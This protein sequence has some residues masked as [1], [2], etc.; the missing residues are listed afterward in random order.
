M[1]RETIYIIT[2]DTFFGNCCLE[3]HIYSSGDDTLE[4]IEEL[5]KLAV[6]LAESEPDSSVWSDFDDKGERLLRPRKLWPE[7]DK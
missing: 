5:K 6:E 3:K 7:E 4:E 1:E 2:L